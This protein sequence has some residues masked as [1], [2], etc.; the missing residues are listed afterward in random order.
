[1]ND[2][3][4]NDTE[5][6]EDVGSCSSLQVATCEPE[7]QC[8]IPQ[9]IPACH[10]QPGN[11][12][13]Y[14]LGNT[15]YM[16]STLQCLLHNTS[17]LEYFLSNKKYSPG[18]LME[19]HSLIEKYWCGKWSVIVPKTFKD[20]IS[21][22]H[23][24]FSGSSQH[25]G[26]EFLALFLGS[27]HLDLKEFDENHTTTVPL[28]TKICN[29]L[30]IP[31]DNSKRRRTESIEYLDNC[32]PIYKRTDAIN[33]PD[34][35][36]LT[37]FIGKEKKTLNVNVLNAD[38]E[39]DE[40]ITTDHSNKY[41]QPIGSRLN[42]GQLLQLSSSDDQTSCS[43]DDTEMEQDLKSEKVADK[44]S[45]QTNVLADLKR[46]GKTNTDV[47]QCKKLFSEADVDMLQLKTKV[48]TQS[49]LAYNVATEMSSLCKPYLSTEFP[50]DNFNF[51]DKACVE[52]SDYLGPLLPNSTALDIPNV[53]ETFLSQVETGDGTSCFQNPEKKKI[54]SLKPH[55]RL[56][57]GLLQSK[58]SPLLPFS[59]KCKDCELG[60]SSNNFCIHTP[61]EQNNGLESMTGEKGSLV[62]KFTNIL[63]DENP[64]PDQVKAGNL[65]NNAGCSKMHVEKS[66]NNAR[67]DSLSK[68]ANETEV[69]N[70][71]I[72]LPGNLTRAEEMWE[73][74]SEK[75]HSIVV[76]NFQGQLESVVSCCKCGNT[77]VTYEPFMYLS[78]PI[79]HALQSVFD[80]RLVP[81]H[82]DSFM[83][84]VYALKQGRVEDLKEA[85]AQDLQSSHHKTF[86][87][88]KFRFCE[89]KNYNIFRVLE[90]T[91]FLKS[92][93]PTRRIEAIET[94][95]MLVAETE[96]DD[97]TPTSSWNSCC[98][99]LEDFAD[100]ELL[101]HNA[102]S[103]SVMICH[104]CV[105]SS[106]EHYGIDGFSCP[107][108]HCK[109][110]PH[111]DFVQ[112]ASTSSSREVIVTLNFTC[113]D[114][115][116]NLQPVAHP[117]LLRTSTNLKKSS[118]TEFLQMN[119]NRLPKTENFILTY[120][121]L[122]GMLCSRCSHLDSCKGCEITDTDVLTLLPGDNIC[123]RYI[124]LPKNFLSD[125]SKL[126][127]NERKPVTL[128]MCLQAFTKN[129]TLD[130]N[131]PWFCVSCGV[132]QIA[133]KQ[134]RI[135]K[136]PRTLI[137]YIKRFLY[138]SK[139]AVKV[140][141]E[142]LFPIDSF[143]PGMLSGTE[144]A[145]HKV[146]DLSACISHYG[147][148]HSGHY[149][150]NCKHATT[151]QWH[152]YNDDVVSEHELSAK[153]TSNVYVLFY[154]HREEA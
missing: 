135:C 111:T 60:I 2:N 33:Q 17:L 59:A 95:D 16:N 6:L 40:E 119:D 13:L 23:P 35:R 49:V 113:V 125:C 25:D 115:D 41:P 88:G 55:N 26:Q 77:S 47:V 136:W 48:G 52:K 127:S 78:V 124:D 84:S 141:D 149:T 72:D 148:V 75:N 31:D 106:V 76:D 128:D 9:D 120:C 147:G 145:Q 32:L 50:F 82:G 46:Q 107:I 38:V 44:R 62:T 7:N 36:S 53:S 39:C 96:T 142:V 14:N 103:C 134:L 122:D 100:S 3:T 30:T 68:K 5:V 85:I 152:L 37:S 15:C 129:E 94:A 130:D 93:N 10:P 102:E 42:N 51:P 116:G 18:V 105:Q 133:E 98:I 123:V 118:L 21:L 89:M 83:T 58:Y 12:G 87:L 54:F 24:Q 67:Y 29:D 73:K 117:L 132:H 108:C 28:N 91:A 153:D 45:K 19:F 27:L 90:N 131:N 126:E 57:I 140:D 63:V 99:C 110:S 101:R 4:D 151:G 104:A 22:T 80:V 121:S 97:T 79:P 61:V 150:A 146:Y 11:C 66:T 143:N 112:L 65:D 69:S 139:T 8:F 86:D 138:H 43:Y 92:V 114:A 71:D 74:Y 109:C 1:M 56:R 34:L 20:F 64:K 154:Q 70:E 144:P 137:L 81:L